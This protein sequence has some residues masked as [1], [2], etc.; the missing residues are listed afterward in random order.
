MAIPT[1]SNFVSA[2]CAA[3]MGV[4]YP[5]PADQYY[6]NGHPREY[7]VRDHPQDIRTVVGCS[8]HNGMLQNG[9]CGWCEY[10]R[11]TQMTVDPVALHQKIGYQP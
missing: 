3:A 2:R 10:E 11:S 5:F 1:P 4:I 9:L 8:V 7:C 6:F